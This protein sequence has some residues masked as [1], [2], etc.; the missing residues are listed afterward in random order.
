MLLLSWNDRGI[1]NPIKD[2][3]INSLILIL[4][5]EIV[6]LIETKLLNFTPSRVSTLWGNRHVSYL[7]ANV[8]H[9][10]SGGLFLMWNPNHFQL[11][12]SYQGVRWIMAGSKLT[13]CNWDCDV[14]LVYGG[15]IV[16]DQSMIYNKLS[17]IIQT[18]H[19]PLLLICDFN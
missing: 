1:N 11:T 12:R 15:H 9:N 10:S 19:C 3:I 14:G 13:S 16:V 17:A 4:K 5:V 6:G 8:V 7:I 18:L 2:I